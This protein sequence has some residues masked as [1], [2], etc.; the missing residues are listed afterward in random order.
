MPT[1]ELTS[2][3]NMKAMDI[4]AYAKSPNTINGFRPFLSDIRPKNGNRKV[5]ERENEPNINIELLKMVDLG[6][7]H[8][9][10]YSL[11]G[12]I[13]GLIMIYRATCEHYGLAP[14]Y[15]IEDFRPDP[16]VPEIKID[17]EVANEEQALSKAVQ[18]VYQIERDNR[19]LRQVLE[20]SPEEI[21]PYFDGLRKNYPVRREFQN[22]K[23][24]IRDT[25]SSLAGKLKGIGF[26]EIER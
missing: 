12:K 13:A 11:D 1:S 16:V 3:A 20:K 6:T 8:I 22:T 7:P 2:A 23:I 19:N 25:N 21:G 14:K 15:G 5:L 10:G 17:S 18:E 24:I 26:R 9:A 4:R